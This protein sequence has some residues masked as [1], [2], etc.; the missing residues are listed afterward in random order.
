MN[1]QIVSKK[2]LNKV[3]NLL[4]L[5]YS[6][7]FITMITLSKSKNTEKIADD[8]KKTKDSLHHTT[9]KNDVLSTASLL[10]NTTIDHS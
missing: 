8:L 10:K 5:L 1:K 2:K 6:L 7:L 9:L 3:K 4:F